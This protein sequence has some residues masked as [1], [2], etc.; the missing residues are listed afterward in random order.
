VVKLLLLEVWDWLGVLE[1]RYV[2]VKL[3]PLLMRGVNKRWAVVGLR[4]HGLL[5]RVPVVPH[6]AYCMH[7]TVV[8]VVDLEL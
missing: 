3:S 6:L 2:W 7:V 5:G 8:F 4:L 1:L